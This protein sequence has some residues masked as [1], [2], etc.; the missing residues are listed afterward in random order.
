MPKIKILLLE[1]QIPK[2][3]E[4]IY[5][6][7]ASS[8]KIDLTIAHYDKAAN[9]IHAEYHEVLFSKIRLFNFI[10]SKNNLG[11]FVAQFDVVITM[12]DINWLSFMSLGL[13]RKRNYKLIYW[14]I[15]VSASYSKK[16]DNDRKWDRLRFFFMRNADALIF[17]SD[18]PIN[19]YVKKGFNRES[20]FVAPNTVV[21]NDNLAINKNKNNIIFVG[22]LYKEKG[23]SEL[24]TAYKKA[25]EIENDLPILEIVGNGEEYKSILSWI[26]K[27]NLNGKIKMYGAVYDENKLEFIFKNAIACV[28]PS[29][30]GLSVLKSMGYGVP[31]VTRFD[32]VTGGERF[33]IINNVNGVFYNDVLELVEI[34]C[35]IKKNRH[36]Y[37]KMGENALEYYQNYR[38]PK[39]MVEGFINAINYVMN[40]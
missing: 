3:R 23:I 18:Y 33:N 16:F 13:K 5:D 4:P 2:Y 31:Y 20:L 40:K 9:N 34:L 27:N 19:K 6:Q 32:A 36:N 10:L 22:T 25:I 29:Q 38:K 37:I 8:E 21:V 15:G 39:H 7:L 14:G 28:S 12:G 35:D 1:N 24:L 30:A 11:K 26:D 17:Y